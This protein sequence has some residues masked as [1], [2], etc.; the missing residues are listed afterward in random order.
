[1]ATEAIENFT[2]KLTTADPNVMLGNSETSINITDNDSK[3]KISS[4]NPI[5]SRKVSN[6]A[7]E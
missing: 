1:M 7:V 5:I 3:C 4:A 6:V 2:L